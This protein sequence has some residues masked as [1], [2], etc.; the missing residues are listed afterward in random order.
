MPFAVSIELPPPRPT[1][2]ST[3]ASRAT[4]RHA[5]T[6][7][8][9]GFSRTCRNGITSSPAELSDFVTA[10]ACPAV[11]MPAS[12]TSNARVPPT[13]FAS[14]PTRDEQPLPKT[15]RSAP[16]TSNESSRA[17]SAGLKE[18]LMLVSDAE[19]GAPVQVFYHAR[20]IERR[21]Q[22]NSNMLPSCGWSH[23]IFIVETG[24]MFSRSICGYASS[25]LMNAASLVIAVQASV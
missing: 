9:V 8:V 22:R 14:S 4:A 2:Q 20:S 1:M 19:G 18:T 11:T 16:A 25:C 15:K 17:S 6:S 5:S 23:E 21:C 24:P 7:R 3:L 13:D 10:P 12:V